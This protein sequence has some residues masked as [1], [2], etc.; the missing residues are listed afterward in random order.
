MNTLEAQ[1]LGTTINNI[2]TALSEEDHQTLISMTKDQSLTIT[3]SVA[4]ARLTYKTHSKQ[5]FWK[6][7][8]SSLKTRIE[9][10]AGRNPELILKGILT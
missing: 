1:N 2:L 4:F 10:E 8:V 9:T 5:V 7:F 6:D 3:Q